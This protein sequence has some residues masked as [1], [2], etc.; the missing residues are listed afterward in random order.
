VLYNR[1][2]YQN[3]V[4]D[5]FFSE[6]VQG[7]TDKN[8]A[9]LLQRLNGVVVESDPRNQNTKQ[10]LNILGM[11]NRYNQVLLGTSVLNSFSTFKRSYPFEML[12][13]EMVESISVQQTG[14][15]ATPSDFAGGNIQIK[16][17]DFPDQNFFLLQ[18]GAGFSK[19]STGKVFY[20]DKQ[21]KFEFLSFP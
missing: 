10:G 13:A 11:G 17:R 6:N 18:I 2:K 5:I 8:T 19:E 7:G 14:D 4:F 1:I 16:V 12:P 21:G 15:A 3:E 9:L 20:G